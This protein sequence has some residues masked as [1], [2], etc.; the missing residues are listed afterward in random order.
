MYLFAER[1]WVKVVRRSGCRRFSLRYHAEDG[2]FTLTI[3]AAVSDYQM[4][5][6]LT[7]QTDWMTARLSE[8]GWQP[9]Y[10]AGERH[11]LWGRYEPLGGGVL[12]VGEKELRALYAR[13]LIKELERILPEQERRMGVKVD[14]I[15]L[16][17]MTSR[18][19]SCQPQTSRIS[20]NL[21]LAQ[22][23][24]EYTVYVLLHEMCHLLHADHSAAFYEELTKVC[25]NA[26]A[27][28]EKI[29]SEPLAPLPSA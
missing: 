19:G 2:T 11:L 6:F 5:K 8:R 13:E 23:P 28:R 24:R 29:K 15:T 7:A 1:Y 22:L 3:P 27:L 18:W 12:P 17:E 20:L 10:A 26:M 4:K 21:R 16:K 25:P 9:S 14:R